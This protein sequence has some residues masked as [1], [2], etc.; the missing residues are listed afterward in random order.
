MAVREIPELKA[1]IIRAKK[2]TGTAVLA[3][4]YV[5]PDI[6]DIADCT[7]DILKLAL[8]AQNCS[9]SRIVVCG[10]ACAAE[11][12]ALLC[13]S[14]EILLSHPQA[15]CPMS[16]QIYPGRIEMFREG[17]PNA[18][19][20]TTLHASAALKG[21]CDLCV[22]ADNA[23][24]VLR[25]AGASEVLFAADQSLGEY[26]AENL[27]EVDMTLIN[28]RCPM[29]SS[30]STQDVELARQKWKNA[31]LAV[32]VSCRRE[33]RQ[34]ADMVGS[35]NDILRYCRAVDWDVI[36]ADNASVRGMLCRELPERSFYQL[37]PSKLICSSIQINSLESV[38]QTI[39]GRFGVKITIAPFIAQKAIRP[40]ERMIELIPGFVADSL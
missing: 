20:A 24:D 39:L 15:R 26:L 35:T 40:I 33:I 22:T 1:D 29:H 38:E 5:H 36:I 25:A 4:H 23:V 34:L 19:V 31:A 16:G 13:P 14:K 3:H 18:L 8:Y 32:N 21:E 30:V 17:H 6:Q 27:P 2:Q 7:G 9:E 28:C 10:I 12:A 11:T 37:A